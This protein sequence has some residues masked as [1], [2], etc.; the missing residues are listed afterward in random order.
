MKKNLSIF[1]C[2]LFLIALLFSTTPTEVQA[3]HLPIGGAYPG[4]AAENWVITSGTS[5]EMDVSKEA[6]TAPAWLQL[7][8]KGVKVTEKTKICHAFRGA[9]FGWVG[10]I[11]QYKD[12]QWIKMPTISDWVPNKEGAF[13]ACTEAPSAGIYALFGYYLKPA[14]LPESPTNVCSTIVWSDLFAGFDGSIIFDGT[15]TNVPSGTT[16]SW[17]IT[18]Y[19]Y[20]SGTYSGPTTGSYA[21]SS[22]NSIWG[23]SGLTDTDLLEITVIFTEGG[24][25]CQSP[26][27][28]F[29]FD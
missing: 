3:D 4:V 26:E 28:V 14:G 1:I 25:S 27:T 10:E 11:R 19:V 17:Q 23:N 2:A 18:D 12:G 6:I 13:M 22:N 9:Q 24:H 7:L 5:S 29:N 20:S 16:I 21:T 15:A 8:T